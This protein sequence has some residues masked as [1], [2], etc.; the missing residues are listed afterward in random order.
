MQSSIIKILVFIFTLI[1]FAQ[2]P[3]WASESAESK[4][5]TEGGEAAEAEG[6]SV[7][8]TGGDGS[9]KEYAKRRSKIA[10]QKAKIDGGIKTIK[11]LIKAKNSGAHALDD[12]GKPID[13]LGKI[14]E[15]HKSLLTTIKDYNKEQE[16]LKYRYPEEGVLY[17]RKYLPMKELTIEQIENEVGLD[18]ELTKTKLKIEKKYEAFVGPKPKKIS[19]QKESPNKDHANHKSAGENDKSPTRLKLS[20]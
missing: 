4:E 14:V 17:Q 19:Q 1:L 18:A 8:A 9:D 7:A 11:D 13:V 6:A 15:E 3:L 16:E 5:A 12:K 2:A 10:V 20:Q